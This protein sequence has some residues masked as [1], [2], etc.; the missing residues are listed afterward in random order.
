MGFI[1]RRIKERGIIFC[2]VERIIQ[3]SQ[4]ESCITCGNQKWKGAAPSL[5]DNLKNKSKEIG[6]NDVKIFSGNLYLNLEIINNEDPKAWANKYLIALW[7]SF[8]LLLEVIIGIK[9]IRLNSSIIHINKIFGEDKAR[10]V[11]NRIQD[12]NK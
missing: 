10:I 6:S 2:Q 12:E 4:L 7:V 5:V 8:L 9:D 3:F 11:L 1:N